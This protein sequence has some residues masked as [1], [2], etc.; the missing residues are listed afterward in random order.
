M[1][2]QWISADARTGRVIADLPG[3]ECDYP[4]RRTIG[5]YETATARFQLDGAPPEWEYALREGG[6]FLHAYDDGDRDKTPLWSG[7]VTGQIRNTTSGVQLTLAT[8][9]AYLDRRYV[10]SVTYKGIG[11]NLIVADLVSRYVADG[12]EPGI[13]LGTVVVTAGDGTPRD[14]LYLDD[15]DA[16][17]YTRL[18]QLMAVQGGPE[19]LIE[20]A[21]STDRLSILPTLLVGDRIG[22]AKPAD[23]PAPHVTFEMPGAV[24]EAERVSDY[25]TGKGANKVTAKSSGQGDSTP[26]SGPVFAADFEGRPTF[27]HRWSPSSSITDTATLRGYALQAVAILAP[28]ARAWTLTAAREDAARLGT[29]WRLGDD[30]GFK[31]GGIDG[32]GRD[33]VAAFPDGTG[34]V[35][36]RAIAYE[37]TETTVSPILAE[38]VIP[39]DDTEGGGA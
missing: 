37:L 15:D 19:F 16:T 29:D 7:M 12:V 9:E 35:V 5:R 25:S 22:A 17:V 34:N 38:A 4:L 39:A 6:V 3:V 33:T 27:E 13:P 36:G 10:G 14:R 21:W 1:A 32:D 20:W 18:T 2:L 24:T 28:G 23:L 26:T 30:V 31:I 8:A 11:Q